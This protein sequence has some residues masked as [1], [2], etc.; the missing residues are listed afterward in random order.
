MICLCMLVGRGR[1]VL[2]IQ[3][4]LLKLEFLDDFPDLDSQGFPAHMNPPY[5]LHPKES[6]AFRFHFKII[7][8]FPSKHFFSH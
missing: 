8:G 3:P 1:F 7:L 2:K 5:S 6:L 4:A